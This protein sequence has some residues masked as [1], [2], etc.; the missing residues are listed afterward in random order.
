VIENTV[1][2]I[3]IV[4]P[5]RQVFIK[6]VDLQNVQEVLKATKVHNEYKHSNGEIS[7]V[8]VDGRDGHEC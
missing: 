4:G 3:Q 6:F 1:N 5:N 8:S 7:L 2:M